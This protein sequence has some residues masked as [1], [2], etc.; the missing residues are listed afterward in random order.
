MLRELA[1]N[2]LLVPA[3]HVV[4][5]SDHDTEYHDDDDDGLKVKTNF[6]CGSEVL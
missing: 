5:T 6:Y 4:E 2:L 1:V 3:P